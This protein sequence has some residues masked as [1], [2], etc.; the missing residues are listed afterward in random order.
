MEKTKNKIK[1]REEIQAPSLNMHGGAKHCTP[2]V[3]LF[4]NIRKDKTERR[5][6][7]TAG[8]FRG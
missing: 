6:K 8:E 3:Q 2:L 1:I 7:E 4:M 5:D